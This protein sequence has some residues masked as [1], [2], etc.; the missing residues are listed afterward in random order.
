MSKR[1]IERFFSFAKRMFFDEIS[2]KFHPGSAKKFMDLSNYL[3]MYQE[4]VDK[5]TEMANISSKDLILVIG[6]GSLP[7]TAVLISMKTKA[8][9]IAID[10]DHKAVKDAIKYIKRLHLEGYIEIEHADGLFYPLNKFDA[11]FLLYGVTRQE[12]LLYS[13][14]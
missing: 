8:H 7:I 13:E 9:V 2:T 10:R 14:Q 12:E 1:V 4:L 5:E 3:K 6:C 11:I